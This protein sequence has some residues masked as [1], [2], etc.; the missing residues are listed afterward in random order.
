MQMVEFFRLLLHSVYLISTAVANSTKDKF[1]SEDL[2][3]LEDVSS[4]HVW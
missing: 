4:E 2:P 1:Y 3:S